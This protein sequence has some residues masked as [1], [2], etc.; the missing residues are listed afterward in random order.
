[1]TS[2]PATDRGSAAAYI[3]A[4]ARSVRTAR[5]ASITAETTASLRA[6]A[7]AAPPV[8]SLR[9]ALRCG[10]QLALI[11]EFK[12]RSPSGGMLSGGDA[13]AG[14]ATMYEACGAGAVSVLTDASDFGG[15]LDD[16]AAAA[17]AVAVPVLR[18]DFL[19]DTA[20][21]YEAR[22]R[23]AAAALLIVAMLDQ[24]ELDAL[25][26]AAAG[27]RLECLVEVHDDDELDRALDAGADLIGINNRDLR[28]LTTDLAVTERLAPRVPAGVV[29]VSESGIR[30][31]ADVARVAAA[32]ADAVL[33]GEA[34]MRT[35]PAARCA[36]VGAF[37]AVPRPAQQRRSHR[38]EEPR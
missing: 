18:K 28:T 8:P 35:A 20:A 21:L 1:M 23:G 34:F 17:H 32:G 14:V 36:V 31:A 7:L 9:G 13:A 15:S 3:A 19:V 5:R 16:L 6:S 2:G 27:V 12:R 30:S 25:L 24:A 4:K 26:R 10:D 33:V 29:L 37:A 38:A 11:A 22:S